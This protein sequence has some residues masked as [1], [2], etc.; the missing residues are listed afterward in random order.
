MNWLINIGA[1][2]LAAIAAIAEWM[3]FRL[4]SEQRR[5]TNWL[6]EDYARQMGFKSYC[7]TTWAGRDTWRDVR[8]A[9]RHGSDTPEG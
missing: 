1:L 4:M 2:G 3:Q 8:P 6:R 7:F 5:Y 9:V